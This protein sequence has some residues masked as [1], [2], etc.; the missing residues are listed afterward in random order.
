MLNRQGLIDYFG[1]SNM[2]NV[3]ESQTWGFKNKLVYDFENNCE[4]VRISDKN[5]NCICVYLKTSDDKTKE[6]K[7]IYWAEHVSKKLAKAC[8]YMKCNIHLFYENV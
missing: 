7:T 3:S 8:S 1:L 4:D 6:V 5:G 2:E